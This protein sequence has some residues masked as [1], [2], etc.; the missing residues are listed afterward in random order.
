MRRRRGLTGLVAL[1]LVVLL[2]ACTA[3]PGSTTDGVAAPPDRFAR[4]QLAFGPCAGYAT[5]AADEQVFAADPRAECARMQ[6]P[7]NHDDPDGPTGEIAMLRV[8]ARG[9]SQ[10]T[11]VLNSGGP[12]GAGMNFAVTTAAALAQSPVTERF[13]LLGF[14]P[15]GVGAS[16]PA[17]ECFTQ[18]Q[19]E[20]GQA[21]TEYFL[22][23]R[24]W[25]EPD[26]ARLAGQCA[27]RSGGEQN[28]AH[29]GSRDTVRDMDL[30]RTV[31]GEDKL[32]FLG[33]SY[34]TRI[35]ALYAEA[36]P[37][38]VGAM[39]L[40]G[41]VDPQSGDQRRLQQYASFQNSFE[42]MAALCAPNAGCALGPDPARATERFQQIV[43]PLLDEPLRD[44]TGALFGYDEALDAVLG[45]L[46]SDA[47]AWK[48]IS[49]GLADLRSG[50]PDRF[51]RVN[52]AV[53]GR[54]P[55]GR[56]SNQTA[57]N[58][59]IGCLDEQR[60]NPEQAEQFRARIYAAA[61]FADPGRGPAGARDA[62]EA[63]PT[64]PDPA[65]PFPDEV[66]GLPPTMTVSLTNDPTT[67]I[68]GARRLQQT[69]GG[70][71]LTVDGDGHTI[72]ATGANPCVNDAVAAYLVDGRP[73]A[74]GARC[75]AIR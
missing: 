35:G 34:G 70:A 59:A 30:L 6:V 48:P 3:A 20:R 17:V 65:Y 63:W 55:D 50:D 69:L 61:P 8:P 41:G 29:V 27:E 32:R 19:Y 26:A 64:D 53:G 33:Q 21:R 37:Q 16:T 52:R 75:A 57:A 43:R 47:T 23:A 72:A 25:T 14:D 51:A 42:R 10:G 58:L 45:V 15:R 66:A 5:S 28:L 12:G 73:P 38:N 60:K 13:D 49:T 36:Y 9:E 18:E 2:G 62:C 7:R 54:E 44:D 67:P 22:S 4:Q 1:P 31:L 24:G 39:V 68:E 40:D 46:L 71:L 56:G 11:L 74:E